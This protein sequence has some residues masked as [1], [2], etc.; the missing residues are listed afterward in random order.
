M[1]KVHDHTANENEN[2]I[3]SEETPLL[4]N[5]RCDQHHNFLNYISVYKILKSFKFKILKVHS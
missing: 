3:V 5:T 4:H 1:L 2:Q